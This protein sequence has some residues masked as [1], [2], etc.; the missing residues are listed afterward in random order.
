M[1]CGTGHHQQKLQTNRGWEAPCSTRHMSA[2]CRKSWHCC[3]L[4]SSPA[5]HSYVSCLPAC[6]TACQASWTSLPLLLL[7][8]TCL[9]RPLVRQLWPY[10][11]LR[12]PGVRH[13]CSAPRFGCGGSCGMAWH[14]FCLCLTDTA[15]R[16][17]GFTI[18]AAEKQ[19]QL[20][21]HCVLV[22]IARLRA[23]RPCKMLAPFRSVPLQLP[24][25]LP[26]HLISSPLLAQILFEAAATLAKVVLFCDIDTCQP[27]HWLHADPV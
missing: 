8:L 16:H 12:H 15:S 1:H 17:P 13:A 18:C 7:E 26:F 5:G 11:Q 9:C 3:P 14:D 24:T 6:C 27:F 4:R 23:R 22:Q 2:A 10:A 20:L 25:K 21:L 19:L